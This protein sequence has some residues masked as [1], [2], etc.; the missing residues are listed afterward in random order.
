MQLFIFKENPCFQKYER[1]HQLFYFKVCKV[2]LTKLI[3]SLWWQHFGFLAVIAFHSMGANSYNR[4]HCLYATAFCLL[5][6]ILLSFPRL[7]KVKA[8]KNV[9]RFS[10]TG[11]IWTSQETCMWKSPLDP[12]KG[13]FQQLSWVAIAIRMG[14]NWWGKL[15]MILCKPL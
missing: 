7:S 13:L 11:W 1:H 10:R 5:W 12:C 6:Q 8:S 9:H 2:Q 14:Q 3:Q 15:E 4:R